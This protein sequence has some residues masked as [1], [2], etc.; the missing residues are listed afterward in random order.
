MTL[1]ELLDVIDYSRES[2]NEKLQ[3]CRP[4]GNW[5]EFDEVGT[6]SAL[7]VPL[8][9]AKVNTIQAVDEDI[10]RVDIDWKEI[11]KGE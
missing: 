10:I 9:K 5:D 8:Y 1:E 6:S 11:I 4:D 2:E 3:V 7:L